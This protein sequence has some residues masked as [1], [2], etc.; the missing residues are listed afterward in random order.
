MDKLNSNALYRIKYA[1]PSERSVSPAQRYSQQ[2]MQRRVKRGGVGGDVI[3]GLIAGLRAGAR[4]FSKYARNLFRARSRGEAAV[5][6]RVQYPASAVTPA[7]RLPL[8]NNTFK[9]WLKTHPLS[10]MGMQ[11]QLSDRFRQLCTLA[12]EASEPGESQVAMDLLEECF[13]LVKQ[14]QYKDALDNLKNIW[15]R[16]E[17]E[18]SSSASS[19][20]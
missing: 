18:V 5:R 15:D 12:M 3:E 14:G 4:W 1:S 9:T 7:Q 2:R 13:N 8:L 10:N 19:S 17:E 20:S 16:L 6:D 11:R